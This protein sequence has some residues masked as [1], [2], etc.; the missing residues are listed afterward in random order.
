MTYRNYAMQQVRERRLLINEVDSWI[1]DE[2]TPHIGQRILEIGCGL[3]NFTRLLL[4]RDLY[5]G[6]DISV[7]SV[8]YLNEKYK[9]FPSI[10][11]ELISVTD[12]NLAN[13]RHYEFDTVI[14]VNVL[15]HIEDDLGAV[16][17]I[18]EVMEN[19]KAIL[20]VPA[21]KWLY[22]SMD[23]HIGHYRR[24]SK[25]SMQEL[26]DAAQMKCEIQIIYRFRVVLYMST[27]TI[28]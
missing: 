16:K 4:D 25:N 20:V 1:F 2:M 3:G 12:E 17:N 19:G 27:Q 10:H 28:N 21:H 13:L 26:L 11:A 22:G 18:R 8:K 7:S 23:K 9:L 15:E 6:V 24:Y 14:S 5:V